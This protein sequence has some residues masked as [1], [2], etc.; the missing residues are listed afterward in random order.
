ML[1]LWLTQ[2]LHR[3]LGEIYLG[4]PLMVLYRERGGEVVLDVEVLRSRYL[5][6]EPGV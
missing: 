2:E 4:R 1:T 6:S 3:Y 5:S